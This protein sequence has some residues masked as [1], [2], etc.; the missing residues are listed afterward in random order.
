MQSATKIS[1]A[2]IVTLTLAA[3]DDGTASH[4]YEIDGPV[5]HLLVNTDLGDVVVHGHDGSRT[6][7]TVELSCRTVTPQPA[8]ALDAGALTV[9]LDAG[10]GASACDGVIEISA[11]HHIAASL[12]TGSGD[13]EIS[14]IDGR[15][16][17]VSYDGN[18]TVDDVDGGLELSVASGD[19]IGAAL[20]TTRCTAEAGAG[21]VDLSFTSTP[22]S[23]DVD[24]VIGEANVTV[25]A[26]LYAIDASTDAGEVFVDGVV[27]APSVD[28][29]L[30]VT[31]DAGDIT[32]IGR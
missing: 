4:S 2:L 5:E 13:I 21:N 14:A 9:S 17:A 30:V 25:P 15:V 11:P 31:A 1:L 18:V 7:I 29:E 16:E 28:N 24:I 8:V 22:I 3:C 20:G 12:R 27:E 23:V 26:S 19:I 6:D 32:I 10:N